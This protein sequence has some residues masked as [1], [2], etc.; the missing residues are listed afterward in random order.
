MKIAYI[1]KKFQNKTLAII[2]KA[3][4]I[5]DEYSQLGFSLTLRQLYYQFV[6]RNILPNTEKSYKN[7]GN[8]VN[9]ARMCGYLDWNAIEDRTRNVRELST[10]DSPKEI[11]QDAT[12]AYRTDKWNNQDYRLEVWI[13]KDALL[14]VIAD[15]CEQLEIPYFSCRGYVSQ[16]EMWRG[17]QRA[18]NCLAEEKTPI[19]IYLGDHDPSGLDMTRDIERR[20]QT[21]LL[22]IDPVE[23]IALNI[24]QIEQYSPP[25]NP[26]KIT[27]TR[28]QAYVKKFGS[29]SWELDALNPSVLTGLIQDAVEVYRDEN[30]WRLAVEKEKQERERLKSAAQKIAKTNFGGDVS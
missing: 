1:D 15:I 11:I 9:D 24:D 16:S 2:Q 27:D 23:R 26:A 13:E 6:A 3:N 8:I 17:A 14:G 22:G 10:W 7:L 29:D 4:E 25:P 12:S 21:F 28:Y 18:N 19:I 20:F 30:Q 5:I